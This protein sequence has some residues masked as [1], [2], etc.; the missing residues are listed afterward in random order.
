MY[1]YVGGNPIS[2]RDPTGLGPFSYPGFPGWTGQQVSDYAQ[3]KAALAQAWA[4]W[5]GNLWGTFHEQDGICTL[6]GCIGTAANANPAVLACCQTH[7]ACY[8]TNQCNASSWLGNAG[9]LA[10]SCQQCNSRAMQC[11]STA[12]SPKLPFFLQQQAPGSMAGPTFQ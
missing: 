10:Q 12:V 6:P 3:W 1:A 2:R 11:I 8:T 7:D 4:L 9:G 5:S